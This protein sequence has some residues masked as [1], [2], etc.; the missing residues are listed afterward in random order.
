MQNTIDVDNLTESQARALYDSLAY[1]YGRAESKDMKFS[2]DETLVWEAINDAVGRKRSPGDVLA[3][4]GK[5]YT[6][7]NFAEDVQYVV[8]WIDQGCGREI[9]RNQRLAIINCAVECLARRVGR[10]K[11]KTGDLL[12]VTHMTIVQQLSYTPAAVDRAYPGYAEA[13]ILDRVAMVA[14]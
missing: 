13:Q 7:K 8:G 4:S 6:R 10:T 12:P 2:T 1:K 14:A 3:K 9:N 11:T 5:T